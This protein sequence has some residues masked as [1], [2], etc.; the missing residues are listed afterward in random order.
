MLKYAPQLAPKKENFDSKLANSFISRHLA[1]H[2][3][4]YQNVEKTKSRL[5]R[6]QP[7]MQHVMNKDL[8]RVKLNKIYERRRNQELSGPKGLNLRYK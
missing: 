6:F 3:E 8:N 4:H 2:N 5:A 1:K 7:D